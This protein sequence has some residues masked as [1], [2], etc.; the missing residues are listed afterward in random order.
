[1][2]LSLNNWPPYASHICC[3]VLGVLLV[4]L[5]SARKTIDLKPG[6]FY[7][8]TPAQTK[9][10]SAMELVLKSKNCVYDQLT[11]VKTQFNGHTLLVLPTLKKSHHPYFSQIMTLLQTKNASFVNAYDHHLTSCRD[12]PKVSYGQNDPL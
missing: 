12:Q 4:N 3:F 7:F 8:A 1:M 6:K 5:S 11:F 2:R 10:P 9:I